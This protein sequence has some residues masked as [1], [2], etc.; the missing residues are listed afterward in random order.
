MFRIGSKT[1][2]ICFI[3][4]CIQF[5]RHVMYGF[6]HLSAQNN[7]HSCHFAYSYAV[8]LYDILVLVKFKK[9]PLCDN[10]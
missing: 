7:N 9:M 1:R 8:V 6:D 3:I 5:V 10:N 4:L 2:R